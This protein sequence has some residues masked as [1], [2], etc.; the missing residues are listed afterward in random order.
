M[1]N[2][3]SDLNCV[4]KYKPNLN[5]FDKLVLVFVML[6]ISL[7]F[8]FLCIGVFKPQLLICN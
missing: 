2:C 5:L 3:E 8:A 7:S 1:C 4:P 6:S